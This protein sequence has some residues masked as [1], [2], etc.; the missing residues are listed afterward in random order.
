MKI[1]LII[2]NWKMNY[3]VEES[4]AFIESFQE[5]TRAGGVEVVICPPFTSLDSVA[6]TLKN[7]VASLGAQNCH[8]M[9][10]GAFTG[11]ISPVFLKELGCRFVLLGHSERRHIFGETDEQ[12]SKK[13]KAVLKQGM[14]SVLCV[15]EKLEEREASK[16]WEVIEA[17]LKASLSD[18]SPDAMKNIVVAYEPVWA[19]GTGKNATPQMAN[20]VHQLIRK[21]IDENKGR[22]VAEGVR[23]LYG[24]SVNEANAVDL[25][26]EPDIDGLLIGGASLKIG[27]FNQ[28][29]NGVATL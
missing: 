4:L 21:W 14:T 17:Q 5:T 8:F 23:I 11:E 7:K 22:T 9:E 13:V 19:I 29:I 18:V 2:A 26:K 6:S 20:E 15:G 10:A 3:G 27:I 1:P 12:I 25:M 28:I 24:G 16:T